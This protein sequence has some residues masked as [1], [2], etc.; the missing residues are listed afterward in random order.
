MHNRM[1][2]LLLVLSKI[3]LKFLLVRYVF[4][5]GDHYKSM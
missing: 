2:I 4:E 5:F 3:I 1:E